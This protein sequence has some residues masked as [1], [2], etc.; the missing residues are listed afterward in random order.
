MLNEFYWF[1][2]RCVRMIWKTFKNI[3]KRKWMKSKVYSPE[4]S[5]HS[6]TSWTFSFPLLGKSLFPFSTN[7]NL[8]KKPS[9]KKKLS[10]PIRDWIKMGTYTFILPMKTLKR[11]RKKIMLRGERTHAIIHFWTLSRYCFSS[12]VSSR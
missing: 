3:W 10:I 6:G 4:I 8:T 11:N 7:D 1:P 5:K 2:F 9:Y 12:W